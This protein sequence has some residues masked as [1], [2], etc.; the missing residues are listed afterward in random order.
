MG[1]KV[2]VRSAAALVLAGLIW[3][4]A[5]P[6][7]AAP[8]HVAY[9]C[10]ADARKPYQ[11]S[12]GGVPYVWFSAEFTCDQVVSSIDVS[13]IAFKDGREWGPG[14]SQ[15]C[16][17]TWVC[18]AEVRMV[19]AFGSHRYQGFAVGDSDGGVDVDRDWSAIWTGRR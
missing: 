12:I 7:L 14:Y 6:A 11:V 9:S 4:G 19:K 18:W 1:S 5:P 15:T 3:T 8:G 2:I 13:V 17:T 16:S 10:H